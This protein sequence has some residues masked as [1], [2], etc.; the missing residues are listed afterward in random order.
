MHPGERRTKA[1]IEQTLLRLLDLPGITPEA[2][3]RAGSRMHRTILRTWR[4][5]QRERRARRARRKG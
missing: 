1:L 5:V 3:E 2:I 4:R